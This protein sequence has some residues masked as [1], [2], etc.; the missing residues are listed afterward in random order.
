MAAVLC[1]AIGD[2]TKGLCNGICKVATLPC[3]ACGMA[4]E[5]ITDVVMTAF[6]P[7]LAVTFVLN[8]PGVYFGI[9]SLDFGCPDL[10][11]WLVTNGLL[12]IVHMVACLYVVKTIRETPSYTDHTTPVITGT[13]V[14]TPPTTATNYRNFSVPKQNEHGAP[15]SI[16]RIKH[17]LCYDKTMA[18]YIIFFI[19]W[20]LWLSYG[21]AKRLAS[22]GGCDNED[23]FMSAAI[24]C[25]YLYFS[26]VFMAFGC[27]LCCLR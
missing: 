2:M 1:G 4:C 27:S 6:F 14:E 5:S 9:R 3:R 26:L 24:S 18:L 19:G 20:L 17:V 8:L 25:G 11:S 10:S 15:N 12:C 21:V 13:D 22:D 23:Q 16:A 7:Y